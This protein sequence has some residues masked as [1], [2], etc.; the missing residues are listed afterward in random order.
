MWR[1]ADTALRRT[2][3]VTR[4]DLAVAILVVTGLVSWWRSATTLPLDAM[5][6]VGIV[7]VLTPGIWLGFLLVGAAF[8]TALRAGRVPAIVL[9]LVASVL[10]LHGLGVVAEPEMRFH[11]PGGTSASPTSSATAAGSTRSSTRTRTG[12][13]SSR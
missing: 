8:F 13:R 1:S 3:A 4:S 12:R 9:S 5:T 11:V 7:S 10:V 2:G 6:D